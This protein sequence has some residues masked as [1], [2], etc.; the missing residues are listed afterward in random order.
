[1]CAGLVGGSRED[2]RLADGVTSQA[3]R[4]YG[5]GLAPP[6]A[7]PAWAQ[8]QARKAAGTCTRCPSGRPTL[9]NQGLE[10]TGNSVRSCLAP[11]LPSSS[12]LAFG[13]LT[14]E[15]VCM[16]VTVISLILSLGVCGIA[17]AQVVLPD[18]GEARLARFDCLLILTIDPKTVGATQFVVG[19][20]TMPPGSV[21]PAHPPP[22]QEEVCPWGERVSEKAL[23][24]AY[25]RTR[26][27]TA[28]LTLSRSI[29]AWRTHSA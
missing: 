19:M 21:L 29:P 28:F 18:A 22:H 9:P 10:L 27:T 1:V 11:A 6:R 14:F 12:G 2:G 15:E 20:A 5:Y 25:D 3:T 23:Y 4:R 7:G 17:S 13:S 26:S 8:T 16:R 24:V